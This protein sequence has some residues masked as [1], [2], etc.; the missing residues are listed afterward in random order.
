MKID[1]TVH[2]YTADSSDI[3][4]VKTMM[5][6]ALCLLHDM[7]QALISDPEKLKKMTESLKDGADALQA[8]VEANQPTKEN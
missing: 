3:R 6:R 1:V 7:A 8:A 2:V 5:A 4:H